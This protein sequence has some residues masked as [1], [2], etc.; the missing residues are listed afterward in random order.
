MA[1]PQLDSEDINRL[2]IAAQ[3]SRLAL[4]KPRETVFDIARQHAGQHYSEEGT[5]EPVPCNLIGV[6]TKITG[7]KLVA[8]NPRALLTTDK[9]EA[10]P[11]VEAMMAWV[12]RWIVKINLAETIERSVFNA[13]SCIGI[14]KVGIADPAQVAAMG[15]SIKAGEPYAVVIDLD[16][17]VWDMKAKRKDQCAFMG[18]RY[19]VPLKAAKAM[20]GQKAK[21][22]SGS[23]D[24]L[25]NL[26]GDPRINLIGKTTLS[27]D[28]EFEEMID[29]WEFYLPRH[30]LVVTLWDGDL[31]GAQSIDPGSLTGKA[32]RI[33]EWIGPDEGPFHIL[34]ME[35]VSGN[36]MPKGPLQDI[37][38]LHLAIN[39]LLN[40]LI[41]QA[42]RQKE[43]IFVSGGA[44]SDGNRLLECND[45][46]ATRV[47]D[48][49]RL[50]AVLWGG[51]D[52]KNFT[53][54]NNLI[55]R[56]SWLMGNLDL[57]GGLGPQSKT[58]KQDELLNQNSSATIADMQAKTVAHAASVVRALIWFWYH[59]PSAILKATYQMEG[60]PDVTAEQPI[61]PIGRGRNAQG[62]R[63]LSRDYA[64]EEMDIHI[65]PYSLQ[66]QSPQE[67]MAA[68][69]QVL[70]QILIP[71]AQLLQQNGV[72]IDIQAYLAKKAKLGDMPDLIEIVRM[73]QPPQMEGGGMGGGDAQVQKPGQTTREYIRRSEGG[74]T[75]NGKDIGAGNEM[76][77][78]ASQNGHPNGVRAA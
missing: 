55:E 52:P 36:L 29:L 49:D 34:G 63:Q 78:Q 20:Y 76:L 35:T 51:P 56:A 38:D 22:L 44:D 64:F 48:P 69:D 62:K 61:H 17:W 53:F 1:K 9:K 72:D 46:E 77:Q 41:D 60:L 15:W 54:M 30:R 68:L 73:I 12:N 42:K 45:G 40:K 13:L 24:L 6:A 2:C 70:T 59:H 28:E 4:R 66:Y 10:K 39:E 33:Q 5:I 57:M 58:A 7:R 26:E 50:K 18:F 25:Y 21:D 19:R 71:L 3:Q 32:L 47:D 14:I 65:D 23:S 27:G 8:A 37:F 16:D 74:P 67:R 31:T 43:V 11:V 75:N